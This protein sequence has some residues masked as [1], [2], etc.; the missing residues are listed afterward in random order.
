MV[1][2][3]CKVVRCVQVLRRYATAMVVL[4]MLGSESMNEVQTVVGVGE[5]LIVCKMNLWTCERG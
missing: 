1:S 5:R 4:P 2:M 3:E